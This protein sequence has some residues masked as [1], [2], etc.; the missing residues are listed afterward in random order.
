MLISI[1]GI[2]KAFAAD[3]KAIRNFDGEWQTTISLLKLKQTGVA[4]TGNFGANGQFPLKGSVSGNALKFEYEE[5][6]AK[7]E[8]QFTLD[9]SGHAFT[10]R[11][12]I[13]NG[14]S[15]YWNGWRSDPGA[16]QGKP[17]NYTGLWLTDFGLMELTQN[18]HKVDA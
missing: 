17:G 8:G 11:F 13:R 5:G 15:G 3:E 16:L 18:E 7:G 14:R 10:G 12:K 6:Q 4:V 9:A 1:T 2:S